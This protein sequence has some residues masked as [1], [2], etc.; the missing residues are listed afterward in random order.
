[1]DNSIFTMLNY[2]VC[3]KGVQDCSFIS[4]GENSQ[5]MSQIP[6]NITYVDMYKQLV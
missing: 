2:I 1:M 5:Q 3:E 4:P 6:Q